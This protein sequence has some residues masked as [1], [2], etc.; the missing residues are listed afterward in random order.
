MK[1]LVAF[2]KFKGSLTSQ[3]LNDV[4]KQAIQRADADSV[5]TQ[6][7]VADGGDG[8]VAALAAHQDGQWLTAMV[9][10]PLPW[11]APVQA[12]YFITTS[13]I[14]IIEVAQASGLSLVPEHQRQVMR[15]SSKGTGELIKH[16]LEQGCRQ[17]VLG[18]GGSATCD[19]GMGLLAALGV[20]FYDI[21]HRQLDA[22]GQAMEH[23]NKIDTSRLIAEAKECS[24]TLLTDV[25]NP[26]YGPHGAAAIY[27]PQKGATPSQVVALERGLRRLATII[28]DDIARQQG[29]GAAGGI[30][31][32]MCHLLHARLIDGAPYILEQNGFSIALNQTDWVITGEGQFDQQSMM[33]K[34]PGYIIQMAK[35][36]HK[37]VTVVCGL[38]D[39]GVDYTTLGV[40]EAIAISKGLPMELAMQPS[41]TSCGVD[42]AITDLVR[43][44]LQNATTYHTSKAYAKYDAMD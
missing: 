44:V 34:A 10:A 4:A 2:D 21:D 33:G 20:E 27:A 14:A 17:V 5:V 6:V 19:G 11:L 36:H 37:P 28:G 9:E 22:C 25:K 41:H 3:Q 12:S 24:F 40:H 18:L 42:K 7:M 35:T 31:A 15:A 8:T 16:A 32:L 30:P 13:N 38:A 26:L 39:E 1:W 43:R 23:I 29:A